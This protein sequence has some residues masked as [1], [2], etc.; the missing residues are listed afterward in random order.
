MEIRLHAMLIHRVVDCNDFDLV[1]ES[2]LM[3]GTLCFNQWTGVH[4]WYCQP[5]LGMEDQ[6]LT[7]V[8]CMHICWR[9]VYYLCDS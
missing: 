7:L 5:R 4:P 6:T 3:I 2:T 8:I 9:N 1:L